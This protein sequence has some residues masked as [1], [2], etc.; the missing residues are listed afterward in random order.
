M[1]VGLQ[2]TW[3]TPYQGWGIEGYRVTKGRP[4]GQDPQG[5]CCRL[6][7]GL[8][9]PHPEVSANSIRPRHL[10]VILRK[11]SSSGHLKCKTGC[12]LT[13]F[14]WIAPERC[15]PFQGR[16]IEYSSSFSCLLCSYQ[17]SCCTDEVF[18]HIGERSFWQR[19]IKK[20]EIK[21]TPDST[22]RS[23]YLVTFKH[24]ALLDLEQQKKIKMCH[25]KTCL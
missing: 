10:R 15:L 5:T 1:G 17:S 14:H 3:S 4:G 25:I 21:I 18:C 2:G 12:V 19:W 13:Y 6:Q 8:M 24:R 20:N 11:S 7:S 23:C 9:V 22:T 16:T